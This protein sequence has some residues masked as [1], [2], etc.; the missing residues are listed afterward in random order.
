MEYVTSTSRRFGWLR[1]EEEP[2]DSGRAPSDGGP[3]FHIA[4]R[5]AG[6]PRARLRQTTEMA[7]RALALKPASIG[8]RPL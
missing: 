5:P 3:G 1:R 6:A 4:R 7:E 2:N 8:L